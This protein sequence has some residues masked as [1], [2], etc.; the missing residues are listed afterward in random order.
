MKKL[1]LVVAVMQ[2]GALKA[3]EIYIKDLDKVALFKAL[4]ARTHGSGLSEDQAESASKAFVYHINGQ[5]MR[6][7]VSKN[8]VDTWL[9]NGQY[10]VNA[11]EKVIEKVRNQNQ[12][13]K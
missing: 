6:I 9:Y 4:Y 10:G 11:A 7:D 12:E 8:W 5:L 1:L 13:N 2:M 3:N